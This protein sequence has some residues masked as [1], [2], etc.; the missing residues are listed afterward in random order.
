MKKSTIL[1]LLFFSM[2]TVPMMGQVDREVLKAGLNA[3]V[4][5]GDAADISSFTL[6][7]DL[8]FHIGVSRAFDLGFATG[9]TNAFGKTES[10]SQGGI[11]I[12]GDF[13]NVQ[14]VPLAGLLRIYPSQG[15]NFG[16]DVGYALGL[17]DG[18]GGGLYYR[19]IVSVNVAQTTEL[20]FSYTGISLDGGTWSTVTLGV[21]FTF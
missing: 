21:L 15:V 6:G 4:P 8:A 12:E 19:P 14:F 9:F 17:N 13:D 16:A 5:I 20:T 10:I 18:N 2:V 1:I 11:S 3:G 7:L